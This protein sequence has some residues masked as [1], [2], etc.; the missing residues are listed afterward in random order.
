MRLGMDEGTVA[1]KRGQLYRLGIEYGG[2]SDR[3]LQQWLDKLGPFTV[4][5]VRTAVDRILEDPSR[6][7]RPRIGQILANLPVRRDDPNS[8]DARIKR[9]EAFLWNWSTGDCL[10]DI[11]CIPLDKRLREAEFALRLYPP[12]Q[13][14]KHWFQSKIKPMILH[15]DPKA[16]EREA[17]RLK[18]RGGNAAA[19]TSGP[20]GNS[21]GDG[22]GNL[23]FEAL[24]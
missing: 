1:A 13:R 17:D 5:Q 11:F 20:V 15:F 2:L 8:I 9:G 3:L 4:D 14:E 18:S 24:G 7:F 23:L 21:E 16:F 22:F 10:G 6:E 19:S 12:C